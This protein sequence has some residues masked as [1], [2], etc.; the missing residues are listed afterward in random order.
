MSLTRGSSEKGREKNSMLV[1]QTDGPSPKKARLIEA[2]GNNSNS[3]GLVDVSGL[4]L[5]ASGE[6]MDTDGVEDVPMLSDGEGDLFP[7]FGVYI[8]S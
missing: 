8:L 7:N 6:G 5:E 2:Q 4:L 3:D 1:L